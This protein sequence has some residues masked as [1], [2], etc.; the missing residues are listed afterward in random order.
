M[1]NIKNKNIF[2]I[3]LVVI[4]FLAAT[5]YSAWVIIN[6]KDIDNPAEYNYREL[7]TK[8]FTDQTKEYTGKPLKPDATFDGDLKLFDSSTY[9]FVSYS[10]NDGTPEWIDGTPTDAGEYLLRIQ[11]M[12]DLAAEP[13]E[14]KFTISASDVIYGYN[15]SDQIKSIGIGG[16]YTPS[17]SPNSLPTGI[18]VDY[19]I[20][21][22]GYNYILGVY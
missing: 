4:L 20:K 7:V 9:K 10:L 6:I 19:Y 14:V 13:I 15:F 2:I 8:V 12:N 3:L 21:D 22:E 11:N 18:T 16:E 1:K 5:G 17:L